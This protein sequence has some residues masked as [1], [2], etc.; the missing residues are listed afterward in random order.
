M[1]KYVTGDILL[2]KSHAIAHGVSP[3]D[4]FAQGLALSL[5]E[6]WPTMYKD[7]R[8]YFHTKSPSEGELWSWKGS[9]G[10]IIINLF[11]QERSKLQ[12]GHPGLATE[13]HVNHALK[14]LAKE[15]KKLKITSLALPK[16]AT[17]VGALSWEKVKPL[18]E[19]HLSEIDI[20][21]FVYE[22]YEKGNAAKEDL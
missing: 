15:A 16:I 20:P 9:E 22:K 21:V 8:H 13:S 6:N 2:T 5:R 1:I 12:N 7:F 19:K 11:T 10:P 17:G 18:I 14:E 4:N 3:T